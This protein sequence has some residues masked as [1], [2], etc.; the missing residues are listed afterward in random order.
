MHENLICITTKYK[1]D[2]VNLD[3]DPDKVYDAVS[4]TITDEV[5]ETVPLK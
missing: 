4:G 2:Q 1:N 3:L 5:H